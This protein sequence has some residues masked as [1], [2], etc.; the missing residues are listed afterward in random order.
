MSHDYYV[1]T[2]VVC[3]NV[4]GV[5][6]FLHQCF[7]S[8]SLILVH[9]SRLAY[10][11]GSMAR[12]FTWQSAH[13]ITGSLVIP[14]GVAR[15]CPLL[16]LPHEAASAAWSIG[17][18]TKR[19]APSSIRVADSGGGHFHPA[20]ITDTERDTNA[21]HRTVNR[22]NEPAA[23]GPESPTPGPCRKSCLFC[24]PARPN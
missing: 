11:P 8:N 10:R 1:A 24:R 18:G 4:L 17:P 5:A 19:D 7:A 16:L 6:L 14:V 21:A 12:F 15:K 23:T 9:A 3:I 22:V 13:C 20:G 2:L